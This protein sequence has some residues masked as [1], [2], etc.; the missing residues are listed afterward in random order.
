MG[1]EPVLRDLALNGLSG[2]LDVSP[3]ESLGLGRSVGLH[4]LDDLEVLVADLS[5][6]TVRPNE[7][8]QH[9]IT[10]GQLGQ[11]LVAGSLDDKWGYLDI[12]DHGPGI[13]EQDRSHIFEPFFTT[14]SSGTGLG[15]YIA[16]ELA[17]CNQAQ[18]RYEAS[19]DIGSRFRLHFA[20]Q[21]TTID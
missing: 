14:E 20:K 10:L 6:V 9:L 3:R 13:P 12:I 21:R 17:V 15:L 8:P 18:L 7:H 4:G 19:E 11:K 5:D 16:R 2:G 1:Y